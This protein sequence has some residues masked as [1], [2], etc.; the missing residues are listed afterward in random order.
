MTKRRWTKA[1]RA[2]FN[3]TIQEKKISQRPNLESPEFIRYRGQL[4]RRI[5]V[6]EAT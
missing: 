6:Q 4:Y 5:H 3:R 2:K 1:R